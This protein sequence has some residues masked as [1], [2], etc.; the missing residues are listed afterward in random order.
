MQEGRRYY[1]FEFTAKSKNYTRHALAS[2]TVGNGALDGDS[3]RG[4]GVGWRQP[5]GSI[6]CLLLAA[7][8]SSLTFVDSGGCWFAVAACCYHCEGSAQR[9]TALS[10][11]PSLQASSTRW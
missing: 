10:L 4:L 9:I 6:H 3:W 2:V 7:P 5:V 8:Y 1:D 11:C